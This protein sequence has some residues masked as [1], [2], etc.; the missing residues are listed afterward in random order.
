MMNL[1]MK[2]FLYVTLAMRNQ[3][4]LC[5]YIQFKNCAEVDVI[6]Q[7]CSVVVG[8]QGKIAST[9]EFTWQYGHEIEFAKAL[10]LD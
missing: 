9:F 7:K 6:P 4:F 3:T 8:D 10:Q 1:V 2:L 5:M